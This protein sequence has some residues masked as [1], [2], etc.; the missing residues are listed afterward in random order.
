MISNKIVR[1]F[2]T[3]HL[4]SFHIYSIRVP[5]TTNY[6]CDRR[7]CKLT[8]TKDPNGSIWHLIHSR[9]REV[10]E[11][12]EELI[13]V[14]CVSNISHFSILLEEN[15]VLFWTWW[16]RIN[17]T[18]LLHPLSQWAWE[19]YTIRLSGRHILQVVPRGQ[20]ILVSRLVLNLS[21]RYEVWSIVEILSPRHDTLIIHSWF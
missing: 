5:F 7:Q 2:Y 19:S 18:S 1:L 10:S 3:L 8:E 15:T 17:Y 13:T 4:Y 11:G 14:L 20:L 6:S 12:L 16:E 21:I 9:P